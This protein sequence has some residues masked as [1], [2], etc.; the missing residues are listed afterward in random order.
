MYDE[1]P[2]QP[3]RR[4]RATR[5]FAARSKSSV[6]G[7][8][9]AHLPAQD[10]PRQII[11][12]SNLERR[13]LLT[14]LAR[15]DLVDIWDQPPA[16][17]YRAE[18]GSIRHHTPDFLVTLQTGLRLAIAVKPLAA[19]ERL[20]FRNELAHVRRATSPAYADELVLV[21]DADLNDADVRNAE[22]L[23]IARQRLDADARQVIRRILA[24]LRREQTFAS[25]VAQSGL[26]EHGWAAM[27]CAI[28]AGEASTDRGRRIGHQTLVY[29]RGVK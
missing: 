16:I 28:H 9:F 20:G 2:Y 24:D 25:I 3:P 22:L 13:V 29:P 11:Y 26:A 4:S 6:R 14:F 27:I 23:H 12:E 17:P 7:F 18:T 5:S 1:T 19:V 21:T 15:R 10:R 8:L